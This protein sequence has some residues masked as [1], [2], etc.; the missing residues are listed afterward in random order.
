MRDTE[1]EGYL[2]KGELDFW[3]G[4]KA[5]KLMERTSFVL[6]V[7]LADGKISGRQKPS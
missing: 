5:F 4:D 1:E 3:I 2:L 6:P 7:S